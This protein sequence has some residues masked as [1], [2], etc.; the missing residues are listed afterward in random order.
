MKKLKLLAP[1]DRGRASGCSYEEFRGRELCRC[2]KGSVARA[3]RN[4][5]CLE[6]LEFVVG[7]QP[8]A[9]EIE[10]WQGVPLRVKAFLELARKGNET[11]GAES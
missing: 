2:G 4:N 10:D 9:Y 6:H 11:A 5:L 3:G 1:E 7:V 8:E